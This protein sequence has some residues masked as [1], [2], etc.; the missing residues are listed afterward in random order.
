MRANA[1]LGSVRSYRCLV[2]KTTAALALLL[3]ACGGADT[4]PT[5][6]AGTW[7][8]SYPVT[9]VACSQPTRSES[10]VI[11]YDV[12]YDMHLGQLNEE[13]EG[14]VVDEGG[15]L[16]SFKPAP[17]GIDPE[18]I[19][20]YLIPGEVPS[21]TVL[22]VKT[23]NMFGTVVCSTEDGPEAADVEKVGE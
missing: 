1:D 8:L 12:E 21:A 7:S 23:S 13:A 14:W 20:V 15:G 11:R 19:D 6:L 16:Y 5:E 3:A 17:F 18:N 2:T 9:G 22:Y 4:D 10:L